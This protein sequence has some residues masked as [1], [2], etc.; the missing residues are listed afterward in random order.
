MM[1]NALRTTSTTQLPP[2]DAAVLAALFQA[3]QPFL[4]IK[5]ADRIDWRRVMKNPRDAR[6]GPW[7]WRAKFDVMDAYTWNREGEV[8]YFVS[9]GQGSVRAVGQSNDR[10]KTRW[11]EVPMSR[12]HDASPMG[13]RGLFH[14]TAWPAIEAELNKGESTAYTVSAI[15]RDELTPLCQRIG[16]PLAQALEVQET[17][18]KRLSYH[19][20]TWVCGL[21]YHGLPLWNKQKT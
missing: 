18:H 19:V 1:E 16:G 20:E 12:I 21:K 4:R 15:F 7:K 2:A 11:K 6:I 10:L 8:L 9:D 13:Q 14:T 5:G 3:T 17:R